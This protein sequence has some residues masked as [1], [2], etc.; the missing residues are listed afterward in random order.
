MIN[1][2]FVGRAVVLLA[3]LIH[4]FNDGFGLR[5]NGRFAITLFH[6]LAA[7]GLKRINLFPIQQP[8]LDLGG[9]AQLID[10]LA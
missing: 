6:C 8:V 9:L 7:F 3:K 4:G 1:R 5:V 2:S 10:G